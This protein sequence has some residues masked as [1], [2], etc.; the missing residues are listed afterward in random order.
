MTDSRIA[1]QVLSGSTELMA[2]AQLLKGCAD[3]PETIPVNE[4]V[5]ALNSLA[6]TVQMQELQLALYGGEIAPE[7]AHAQ[8]AALMGAVQHGAGGVQ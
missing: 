6:D 7:E 5:E 1:K 4:I 2:I 8:T 3:A